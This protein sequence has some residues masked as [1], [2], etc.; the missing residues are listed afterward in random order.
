MPEARSRAPVDIR[1]LGDAGERERWCA[2]LLASCVLDIDR[3]RRGCLTVSV[4]HYRLRTGEYFKRYCGYGIDSTLSMSHDVICN[5]DSYGVDPAGGRG[6]SV[7]CEGGACGRPRWRSAGAPL[8]LRWR[9][10]GA[11]LALRWRSAGRSSSCRTA[12]A[13]WSTGLSCCAPP[14]AAREPRP[15]GSRKARR[16]RVIAAG[17]PAPARAATLGVISG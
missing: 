3:R 17:A 13:L 10:A 7:R 6:L 2:S 14:P 16:L 15:D 8:A 5:Y 1:P 9:S 12:C 4:I 11:P